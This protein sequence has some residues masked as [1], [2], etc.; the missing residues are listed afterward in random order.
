MADTGTGESWA[1]ELS[2]P[3]QT[4]REPETRSLTGP[5]FFLFQKGLTRPS[6]FWRLTAGPKSVSERPASLS[7]RPSPKSRRIKDV[8]YF[9]Y[10]GGI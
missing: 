5:F 4:N 10:L 1:R 6:D 8:T 9:Q 7:T 3:P 2:A